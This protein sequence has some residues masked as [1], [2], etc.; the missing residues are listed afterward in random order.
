MRVHYEIHVTVSLD[1]PNASASNGNY[2]GFPAGAFPRND[3]AK[4][5]FRFYRQLHRGE[6]P[7][8]QR[9]LPAVPAS[10]AR[11]LVQAMREPL[12]VRL[13]LQLWQV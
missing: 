7:R 6:A 3:G 9:R 8:A 4:G 13:P 5:E 11:W 2:A 1:F 12:E 10:P